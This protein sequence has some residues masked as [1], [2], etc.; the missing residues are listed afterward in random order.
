MPISST[1]RKVGPTPGNGTSRD[2][3]FTFKVFAASDIDVIR[4]SAN[5]GDASLT[6]P[7][8][9]VVTLNPDQNAA[10]GGNV[11]LSEALPTGLSLTILSAVPI[12][13]LSNWQSQG[14]FNPDDLDD[15]LD[16][17]TA[18]SQQLAEQLGRTLV[19][20]ATTS[21][22]PIQMA[23]PVGSALLA[24]SDDGTRVV[25]VDPKALASH[26]AYSSSE[27]DV[28][29]GDGVETIFNLSLDAGSLA[30]L[31]VSIAGVAQTPSE[32]FQWNGGTEVEF[33]EPPGIGLKVVI[34][35][36][37]V[38]ASSEELNSAVEAAYEAAG[39]AAGAAQGAVE[40]A[41]TGIVGSFA[42]FPDVGDEIVAAGGETQV[43]MAE[44]VSDPN[45]V[46]FWRNG[47]EQTPVI[48]F[49]VSGDDLLLVEPLLEGETV[50]GQHVGGQAYATSSA[51]PGDRIRSIAERAS[52]HISTRDFTTIVMDGE[53]NDG[54]A[55]GAALSAARVMGHHSGVIRVSSNEVL[56]V[57]DL[58]VP[59]GKIHIEEGA[60]LSAPTGF[61]LRAPEWAQ[62]FTG[63]GEVRGLNEAFVEWFGAAGDYD[64]AQA[65]G[66]VPSDDAA[67]FNRAVRASQITHCLDRGYGLRSRVVM[68][69]TLGKAALLK[70]RGW[71]KAGAG[72]RL[73]G[74]GGG[75]DG[76]G[77]DIVGTLSFNDPSANAEWG[78]RDL[79]I[80]P[81]DP[82][83]ILL[84][85]RGEGGLTEKAL[86][87]L[88]S[89]LIENVNVG[90]A[91]HCIRV[92]G[93]TKVRFRN[94]YARSGAR[95]GDSVLVWQPP[96]CSVTSEIAFEGCVLA[97]SNAEGAGGGRAFR[98]DLTDTA[99]G[100]ADLS[101]IRGITFDD[102]C[103]LY[104][105][106][107]GWCIYVGATATPSKQRT[108]GDITVSP[109]TKLQG[110]LVAQGAFYADSKDG[111]LGS[112]IDLKP[113][114][115]EGFTGDAAIDIKNSATVATFGD[116]SDI[117]ISGVTFRYCD[118]AS[119]RING[120]VGVEIGPNRH[121]Y[122][123]KAGSSASA[124]VELISCKVATVENQK[125]S[126]KA[127]AY[128]GLATGVLV[129]GVGTKNVRTRN[130][131]LG[132]TTP[133]VFDGSFPASG[134]STDQPSVTEQL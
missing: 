70:G 120:A 123:G 115:V 100:S 43:Q 86:T 99:A 36:F 85:I 81:S 80:L 37:A 72:T 102:D 130:N 1:Q 89:N 22:E 17:Q 35:Y 5:G 93:A 19:V 128:P 118:N 2:F 103:Q 46:R 11:R 106:R 116:T 27:F 65:G 104:A 6:Q 132:T 31:R 83:N 20:P 98:I 18:V 96:G 58:W 95:W 69:P 60:T 53:N 30:N 73:F 28:F 64:E 54:P 90:D 16:R 62:V 117:E 87:S 114:Q 59:G 134:D 119:V 82:T 24:W 75:A 61:T 91:L 56:P 125:A 7:S 41:L 13:Q 92:G 78:V 33:A 121:Q 111:A 55:L 101:Q 8:D 44:T 25:N 129:S 9:Y 39:E 127:T 122:C 108:W 23:K 32:D 38:M 79:S 40:N 76:G 50:R 112:S 113:R 105:G 12:T 52:E 14:G 126:H 29:T 94:V 21:D 49:T 66:G 26:A 88:T 48:H 42:R 47:V 3:P 131:S 77:V 63:A 45:R 124:H 34:Q 4:T 57:A 71:S 51:A 68:E 15:D 67:A 74:L 133:V 97:Q 110:D 84:D 109:G 10:P 107:N